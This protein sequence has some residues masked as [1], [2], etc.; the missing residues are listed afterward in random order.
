MESDKIYQ[1][2]YNYILSLKKG[3]NNENIN[4]NFKQLDQ[5]TSG[6]LRQV[7]NNYLSNRSKEIEK[8]VIGVK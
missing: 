2:S 6:E 7:I 1:D 5:K 8:I 4:I 3:I